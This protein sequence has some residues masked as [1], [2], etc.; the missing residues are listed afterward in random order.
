MSTL[1]GIAF[2]SEADGHIELVWID[3]ETGEELSDRISWDE[4]DTAEDVAAAVDQALTEAAPWWRQAH[5]PVW[6][7]TGPIVDREFPI[8]EV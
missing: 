6:R 8:E 3:P 1:H 2:I 4:P 5:R 7:R